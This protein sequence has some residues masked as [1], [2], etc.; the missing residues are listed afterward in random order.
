[1]HGGK[2]VFLR[3][4]PGGGIVRSDVITGAEQVPP[5]TEGCRHDRKDENDRA[6][7]EGNIFGLKA[8]ED[9]MKLEFAVTNKGVIKIVD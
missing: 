3:L 9:L 7:D 5:V 4:G 1:M 2:C 8:E 6:N